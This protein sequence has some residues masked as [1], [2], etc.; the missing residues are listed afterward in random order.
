MKVFV[1]HNISPHLARGL[2]CILAPEGHTVTA[3]E[4]KFDRG[5]ADATW[6]G[7]LGREGGWWVLSDDHRV[8]TRPPERAAWRAANMRGLFLAKGWRTLSTVTKAGRLLLSWSKF[9]D[10]D[11]VT[12]GA[13]MYEVPIGFNTGLRQLPF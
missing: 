2:H 7:Q 11:R 12:T 8:K 6:I 9:V 5:V 3:L 1:D 10:I 4:D 13:A